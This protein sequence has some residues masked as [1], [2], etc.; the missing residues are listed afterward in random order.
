MSGMSD[1]LVKVQAPDFSDSNALLKSG[2]TTLTSAADPFK[3]AM[4]DHYK[5]N[6][7]R[8]TD[9]ALNFIKT[10]DMNNPDNQVALQKL[11]DA[12]GFV[13]AG[14]NLGELGTAITANKEKYLETDRNYKVLTDVGTIEQIQNKYLQRMALAKTDEERAQIKADLENDLATAKFG[15]S[16]QGA[17]IAATTPVR[18]AELKIAQALGYLYQIMNPNKGLYGPTLEGAIGLDKR[19]NEVAYGAGGALRAIKGEANGA[20]PEAKYTFPNSTQG[21]G[22]GTLNS[23]LIDHTGKPVSPDTIS[24]IQQY[25]PA[26]KAAAS[27][28][29]LPDYLVKAIAMTESGFNPSAVSPVGAA[30]IMQ[31]M[32]SNY[33]GTYKHNPNDPNQNILA[34]TK[35]FKDNL[36]YLKKKYGN[37]FTEEDYWALAMGAYNAGPGRVDSAIKNAY[38]NNTSVDAS[39][40]A[41]YLP[42][43]TRDYIPRIK[44]YIK[45]FG[46]APKSWADDPA[47]LKMFNNKVTNNKSNSYAVEKTVTNRDGNKI[48]LSSIKTKKGNTV[49]VASEYAHQF[50]G[51]I[52]DLEATGY[53]ISSIGGYVDRS[54]ANDS[55]KT[56][57]HSYGYSIDINPKTNPNFKGVSKEERAKNPKKYTDMDINTVNALAEKW[58]IGWGFN[59]DSASDAMHFSVAPNEGGKK[60]DNVDYNTN[61]SFNSKGNFT[62]SNDL[63]DI[64]SPLQLDTEARLLRAAGNVSKSKYEGLSNVER[65]L[66]G[67]VSSNPMDMIMNAT[68]LGNGLGLKGIADSLINPTSLLDTYNN[69][70]QVINEY[71]TSR[72]AINENAIQ[73]AVSNIKDNTSKLYNTAKVIKDKQAKAAE[74]QANA[75]TL[76]NVLGGKQGEAEFKK[77]LENKGFTT[78]TFEASSLSQQTKL[79]DDYLDGIGKTKKASDLEN[80]DRIAKPLQPE[81][82]TITGA[83]RLKYSSK[84]D[85]PEKAENMAKNFETV[86]MPIFKAQHG[87]KIPNKEYSN[88]EVAKI[89][90]DAYDIYLGKLANADKSKQNGIFFAT[91]YGKAL[92]KGLITKN[93]NLFEAAVNEAIKRNR[94]SKAVDKT[95]TVINATK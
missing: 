58:G 12:T 47:I 35:I 88:E 87:G 49:L 57:K 14:G 66:L 53:N 75:N 55:S 31:I 22:A 16:M 51:F 10:N 46:P 28:L 91:D 60:I 30:G 83:I 20:I 72:D 5:D 37:K 29:G 85:T 90:Y 92:K 71:E 24:K 34:G 89:Y 4:N 77:W 23:S 67:L 54:N 44:H 62:M 56:S 19:L 79:I 25:N 73:H 36:T 80:A 86:F 43:E 39:V 38:K 61:G 48:N 7:K 15:T 70:K 9:T 6:A 2:L 40:V 95:K 64:K 76:S 82:P 59:W 68:S 21:N 74:E 27:T 26:I 94:Q 11:M 41:K 65:S 8:V 63:G 93:G 1:Y 13:N 3:N 33:K 17:A 84:E 45:Q 78:D 32:P 69:Q 42:K 52:N 50:Q 18:E 81:I